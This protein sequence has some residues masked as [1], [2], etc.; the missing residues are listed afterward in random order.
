L[1]PVRLSTY[2]SRKVFTFFCD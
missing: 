2:A 1:V